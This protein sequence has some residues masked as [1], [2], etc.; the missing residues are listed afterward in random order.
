MLTE[1]STAPAFSLED[2]QGNI[3]DLSNFAGKKVVLYFYPKDSTPGCTKE[4][5]GFR[6]V[7][8][9]ILEKGAV[10]LG[11][12]PDSAAS[13]RK[14]RERENLPFYLL[15]D[16]GHET[17]LAYGVWGEK[18]LYGRKYFGILRTTFIIDGSGRIERIFPKVK[19]ERHG[20]E[21][22]AALG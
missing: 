17:A 4:A 5:C 18:T 21:I 9:A 12:S 8:D 13:H 22:L 11:V 1:G 20:A 14:F 7:Y 10:I 2:D 16:G 15:V 3:I 6:D 19:P